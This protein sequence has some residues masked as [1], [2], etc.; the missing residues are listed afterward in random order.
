MTTETD[1]LSIYKFLLDDAEDQYAFALA[2]AD[3]EQCSFFQSKVQKLRT[4]IGKLI[5]KQMGLR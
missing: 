1:R 2:R 5:K 3:W 4:E